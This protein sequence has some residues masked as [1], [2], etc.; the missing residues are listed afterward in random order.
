MKEYSVGQVVFLITSNGIVPL[1]V[2]EEIT[3]ISLSG[4]TKTY[5]FQ[6][7]NIEIDSSK[8][9]SQDNIFNTLED[10]ENHLLEKAKLNISKLISSARENAKLLDT[11]FESNLQENVESHDDN[12]LLVKLPDGTIAKYKQK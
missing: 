6:G 12:E 5:L 8:L 7:K 11:N 1:I 9:N 4:K 10:L 2:K 3:K